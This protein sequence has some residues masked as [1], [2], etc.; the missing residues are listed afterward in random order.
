MDQ[1]GSRWLYQHRSRI[2]AERYEDQSFGR[3]TGFRSART[4]RFW[5]FALTAK[6]CSEDSTCLA[7]SSPLSVGMAI[8]RD[9]NP[10]NSAVIVLSDQRIE[11]DSKLGIPFHK[12][13]L[14]QKRG[15]RTLIGKRILGSLASR[16]Q[17]I[18]SFRR[19]QTGTETHLVRLYSD[20]SQIICPQFFIN[21][22][23]VR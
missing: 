21:P 4:P 3:M 19:R 8:P 20:L 10:S 9:A 11:V 2:L 13:V 22:A 23:E 1:E 18:Y 14:G 6:R 16:M 12:W 7:S 15:I 5:L 17:P